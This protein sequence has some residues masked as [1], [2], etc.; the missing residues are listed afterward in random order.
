MHRSIIEARG[1]AAF[2]AWHGER[3][4]MEPF[5]KA[6]GLPAHLSRWQPTIDAML[7][8][9]DT[10]LPVYLM[11]DESEVKAGVC[12]RRPG[13]H[14]DGYWNP[15]YAGHQGH[16]P[17]SSQPGKHNDQPRPLHR[18]SPARHRSTQPGMHGTHSAWAGKHCHVASEGSMGSDWASA[19]FDAPEGIILAS[20]VSAAQGYLGEYEGPIGDMGD[21]AHIDISKLDV[22]PMQAG[23]VYAGNVNCLHES[24]PVASDCCRSLVR[25]NVPGWTPQAA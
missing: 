8:G 25:L 7:D 6:E 24:L 22:L 4:Y 21:C 2:P 1:E 9:I 13:L 10:D 11:I 16:L 19:R 12:Q 5:L 17:V 20:T 23:R 14:I 15:A 3:V 18:A